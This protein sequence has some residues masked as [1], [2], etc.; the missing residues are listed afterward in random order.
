MY[1]ASGGSLSLTTWYMYSSCPQD[2]VTFPSPQPL[3]YTPLSVWNFA[4]FES[5]L[6]AKNSPK[7]ILSEY[8]HPTGNV[9]PTTAHCGSPHRHRIFPRSWIRHV[10]MNHGGCPSARADSAA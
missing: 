8:L 3:S 4:T 1:S 10:R 6:S 2:I 5:G 7:T 9:S